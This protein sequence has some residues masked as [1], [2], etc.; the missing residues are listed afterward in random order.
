MT[1]KTNIYFDN[2]NLSNLHSWDLNI[3]L[4]KLEQMTEIL[5]E[6]ISNPLKDNRENYKGFSDDNNSKGF[7]SNNKNNFFN[8]NIIN[9][10]YI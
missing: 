2:N 6:T 8:Q 3:L 4:M 10:K 7:Y 9:W 1:F 5:N